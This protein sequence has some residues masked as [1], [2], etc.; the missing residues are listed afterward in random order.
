MRK[1]TTAQLEQAQ[2]D[3]ASATVSAAEALASV[4]EMRAR[5]D[6]LNSS[7]G[8]PAGNGGSGISNSSAARRHGRFVQ[9]DFPAG[10]DA[11]TPDGS[12]TQPPGSGRKGYNLMNEMGLS[13]DHKAFYNRIQVCRILVLFLF[14]VYLIILP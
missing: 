3:S 14:I 13:K 8:G 6:A 4:E 11:H 5:V 9:L 10:V 7:G 1:L 12:I 2:S